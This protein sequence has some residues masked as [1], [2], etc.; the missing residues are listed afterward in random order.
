MEIRPHR[1]IHRKKTKKIMVG[2]VPVGGDSIISVQSM[3]NTITSDVSG[4]IK[5]IIDFTIDLHRNHH[6]HLLLH[7]YF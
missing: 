1:T 5:Q 6:I 2:K 3:T 7:I 4:T